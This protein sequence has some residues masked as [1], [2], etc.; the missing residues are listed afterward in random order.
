MFNRILIATISILIASSVLSGIGYGMHVESCLARDRSEIEQLKKAIIEL[1]S[2]PS[3]L[4]RI[5][6]RTRIIA[7]RLGI[8]V[9]KLEGK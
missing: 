5:D 4:R 1:S 8:E 2:V 3:T 6:T 7:E 9:D